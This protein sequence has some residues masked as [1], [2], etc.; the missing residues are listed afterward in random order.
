[1][2]EKIP[3]SFY[4]YLHFVLMSML[5]YKNTRVISIKELEAGMFQWRIPKALRPVVIKELEILG[6]IKKINRNEIEIMDS[7]YNPEDLRKFY[8]CVGII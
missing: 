3:C 2:N 1:M 7:E 4:Y 8:E 5:L 6:L